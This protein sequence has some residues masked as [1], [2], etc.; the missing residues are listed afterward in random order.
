MSDQ[1]VYYSINCAKFAKP[2]VCEKALH[3]LQFGGF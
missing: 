2:S 3:R 1:R